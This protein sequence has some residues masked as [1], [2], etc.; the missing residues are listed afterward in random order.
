[1]YFVSII[2]DESEKFSTASTSNQSS[3]SSSSL[4]SSK[5]SLTS[6]VQLN[7]QNLDTSFDET[8]FLLKNKSTNEI[9]S[10]NALV[11]TT[12]TSASTIAKIQNTNKMKNETQS[13]KSVLINSAENLINFLISFLLI[14]KLQLFFH[15]LF[16]NSSIN[17]FDDDDNDAD[18]YYEFNNSKKSSN[19]LNN[20][21]VILTIIIIAFTLYIYVFL[22]FVH[23]CKIETQLSEI[24]K[25]F[26]T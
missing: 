11:E 16:F 17:N 6:L 18:Y 24:Q 12:T 2:I 19:F 22:I 9:L 3:L 23:V 14:N 20:F 4:S 15:Y 21:L 5:S 10:P 7:T 26:N 25:L 1:M 13:F 8:D